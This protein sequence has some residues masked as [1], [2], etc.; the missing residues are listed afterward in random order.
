[1]AIDIW[2]ITRFMCRKLLN[3]YYW[4]REWL[5]MRAY[6]IVLDE[7]RYSSRFIC[8]VGG[9]WYAL[10][11]HNLES[12]WTLDTRSTMRSVDL[13]H[14]PLW[15]VVTY[16]TAKVYYSVSNNTKDPRRCINLSH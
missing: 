8:T 10:L 6:T 14:W 12:R 15:L 5:G 1:M 11:T 3:R 4:C 7:L 16:G 13:V 9:P 2:I